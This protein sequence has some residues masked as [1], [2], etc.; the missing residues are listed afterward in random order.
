[1][2]TVLLSFIFCF[3][4][5]RVL[6]LDLYPPFPSTGV[7]DRFTIVITREKLPGSDRFQV[8]VNGSIPAPAL[9]ITLGNNV[10]V[11]VINYIYDDATAIH[12]HGIDLHGTPWMDGLINVTQCPISNHIDGENNTFIYKFTPTSPGTF[13]YHGHYHNQYPDGKKPL[14]IL[15]SVLLKANPFR[16]IRIIR[17]TDRHEIK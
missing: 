15:L 10:E 7:T 8:M 11:K 13:W 6:S 3:F 1:M 12:W 17:C 9:R 14:L 16:S 5:G 4:F 2:T